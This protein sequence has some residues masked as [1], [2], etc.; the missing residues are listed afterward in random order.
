MKT[1]VWVYEIW[2]IKNPAFPGN[3]NFFKKVNLLDFKKLSQEH[4][5]G[6]TEFSN[7]LKQTSQGVHELWSDIQ[8]DI[9]TLRFD[10]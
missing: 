10:E 6:C 4:Y 2:L 3:Q 9:D 7:H 8:T 1:E 5:G